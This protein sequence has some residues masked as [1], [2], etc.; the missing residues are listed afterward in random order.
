MEEKTIFCNHDY[1][2]DTRNTLSFLFEKNC[3]KVEEK[4]LF[5]KITSTFVTSKMQLVHNIS[6]AIYSEFSTPAASSITIISTT[7]TP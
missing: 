2:T 6:V 4:F 1:Q 3:I 7:T 5:P